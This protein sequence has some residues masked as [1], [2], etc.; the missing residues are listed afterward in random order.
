MADIR[1]SFTNRQECKIW[2]IMG[3]HKSR[4]K[5]K[6][7]YYEDEITVA[8]SYVA[9][10]LFLIG[11]EK[12]IQNPLE[13]TNTYTKANERIHTFYKSPKK[14]AERYGE[15][16]SEGKVETE[17]K[18]KNTGES[19]KEV[20]YKKEFNVPVK[21]EDEVIE[22]LMKIYI[23]KNKNMSEE[24]RQEALEKYCT[25]IVRYEFNLLTKKYQNNKNLKNFLDNKELFKLSD[26][27]DFKKFKT[28]TLYEDIRGLSN[29]N[30]SRDV[31]NEVF[32]RLTVKYPLLKE[33]SAY[34]KNKIKNV[35]ASAPKNS[36]LL[37]DSYIDYVFEKCLKQLKEE[38]IDNLSKK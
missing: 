8:E 31:K 35:Y 38:G 16:D 19:H 34:L 6:S 9:N 22:F 27:V 14:Y 13:Y 24:E 12:L 23:R 37:T 26:K 5:D 28:G 17:F 32:R 10:R 30:R 33:K 4:S 2:K 25:K 36:L 29:S 21:A 1:V 11:I 18:D 7:D 20:K 3:V 15:D